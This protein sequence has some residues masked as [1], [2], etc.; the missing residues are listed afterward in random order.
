MITATK[1]DAVSSGLFDPHTFLG[2]HIS[3]RTLWMSDYFKQY[4]LLNQKQVPFRGT[5]GIV[6]RV[7][8][9]DMPDQ[10]IA[11]EFFGGVEE[12]QSRALTFDQLAEK[13][14]LHQ[15]KKDTEMKHGKA[16]IFYV[17]MNG[18]L[19][20]I[21]IFWD[22]GARKLFMHGWPANEH[23]ESIRNAGTLVFLN[24]TMRN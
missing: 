17:L 22:T 15:E 10:E 23:T 21:R 18:V 7:L 12:M 19:L 20:V 16:N 6:S 2:E 5:E 4:L 24:T 8:T 1:N 9:R 3:R 13:I 11:E 14:Y